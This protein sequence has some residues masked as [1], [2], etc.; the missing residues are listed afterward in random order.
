MI[1]RKFV[2]DEISG[3]ALLVTDS[4]NASITITAV[5]GQKV[6]NV[7][8]ST[9]DSADSPS[10]ESVEAATF[11]QKGNRITVE[12]PK[13]QPTVISN[14]S[15]GGSGSIIVTGS[16]PVVIGSNNV[17]HNGI[18]GFMGGQN[19]HGVEV[20][21]TVPVGTAVQHD[22][23]D[24]DLTTYG[25]LNELAAEITN[26]SINIET[27][28]ALKVRSTHGSIRVV[29]VTG[30]AE[31]RSTN[32]RISV[33]DYVGTDASVRATNGRI[34]FNIKQPASGRV[35]IRTS[36][37][38]IQVRGAHENRAVEVSIRTSNGSISNH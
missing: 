8:V 30:T 2:S 14:V 6:V 38:S 36:N 12:I 20:H 22:G 3:P 29:R 19:S 26:G 35:E 7:K 33:E 9:R 37:G 10:A 13:P 18:V 21:I 24:G 1:S 17:V 4:P 28:R 23:T 25:P 16:R 27:V 5:E 11:A 15:T 34:S 31:I 32:G